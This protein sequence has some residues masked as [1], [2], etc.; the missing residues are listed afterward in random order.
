MAMTLRLNEAQRDALRQQAELEGRSMQQPALD[1][2]AQYLERA[3]DN[4]LTDRL[5]VRGSARFKE[6]LKR[7]GE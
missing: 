1:A 7:L 4:D 3:A 2:V 5:A 6:L